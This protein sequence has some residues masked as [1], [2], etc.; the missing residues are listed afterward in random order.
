MASWT[1][2]QK[3]FVEEYCVD[4]NATQAAI[5]AGYSEKTAHV[6]GSR[7]LS[8]PDIEAA[9]EDRLDDLAMSAAEATKRLGDIARG[10]ISDFFKVGEVETDTGT[11]EVVMLDK[12]AVLEDGGAVV[13][14]LTFDANGRPKL[15]LYDKQKALKTILDAHGEFNHE[16]NVDITSGGDQITTIDFRPP[17]D[18]EPDSDGGD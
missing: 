12:D 15:K 1:D 3:R 5:R 7:N 16:Q 9:I 17:S 14:E 2:K 4:F 8:D 6:A 11:K 18:S 10:D 13:K